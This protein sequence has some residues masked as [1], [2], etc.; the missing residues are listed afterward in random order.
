MQ[1]QNIAIANKIDIWYDNAMILR[2]KIKLQLQL[3]GSFVT[4]IDAKKLVIATTDDNFAFTQVYL[5]YNYQC[6]QHI[7]LK[8]T[9]I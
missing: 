5:C 4:L 1:N 6:I 7:Q 3:Q 2:Y 8:C 9:N